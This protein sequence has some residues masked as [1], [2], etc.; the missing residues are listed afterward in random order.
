MR[1]LCH[2]SISSVDLGRQVKFGLTNPKSI[3]GETL[4]AVKVARSINDDRSN[5][6]IFRE[7]HIIA[8]LNHKNILPLLGYFVKDSKTHMYVQDQKVDPH[9]LDIFHGDLNGTNALISNDGHPK[10]IDFGNCVSPRSPLVDTEHND[11]RGGSTVRWMAPESIDNDGMATAEGDVWAFGMTA[12]ELFTRER[13]FRAIENRN[14]VMVRINKGP[15]DRPSEESTCFR[16]TEEWWS[17]ICSACWE[18]DAGDRPQMS[19][20]LDR[21]GAILS[22]D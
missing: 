6:R 7:A 8:L 1:E 16:M 15:S 20:I 10:L 19:I 12:L 22:E 5:K 9:P 13:P 11:L 4:V 17:S 18:H 3:G 2:A 21:I 14:S